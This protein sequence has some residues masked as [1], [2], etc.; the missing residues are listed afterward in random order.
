M[1]LL[2]V[3]DM[4][5]DFVN[6]ALGS[7]EA[8][9]IVPRVKD[10]VEAYRR[11]GDRIIFT[12]DTH[13]EDYLDT[14]EGKSL[15]VIH[16]IAGTKGHEIIEELDTQGCDILDK[17][18]FGTFQLG[19]RIG[20][21]VGD[22]DEIELCGLCSDICVVSN[23][24]ILKTKFPEM[25]ITVSVECCAGVT[26]QSHQAALLTMKMCQIHVVGDQDL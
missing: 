4:Q 26:P 6:G 1:K 12:R 5:N 16:C 8:R 14:Q 20:E 7:K 22:I 18:T 23:A 25:L 19:E 3:I 11:R 13:E 21:F 24:L 2:V 17:P 15:P 9:T 10:K